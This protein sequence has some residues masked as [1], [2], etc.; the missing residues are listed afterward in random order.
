IIDDSVKQRKSDVLYGQYLRFEKR[1]GKDF[2]VADSPIE[3]LFRTMF[4]DTKYLSNDDILNKFNF[5]ELD[6]TKGGENLKSFSEIVA[7]R[8]LRYASKGALKE[9]SP[10]IKQNLA[11]SLHLAGET[12]KA[13]TDFF[14]ERKSHSQARPDIQKIS[15]QL[16]AM[17]RGINPRT[18]KTL[19]VDKLLEDYGI[20]NVK[21][22]HLEKKVR[23]N[24]PNVA[25]PDESKPKAIRKEILINAIKNNFA[26]GSL[27]GG[28]ND[29]GMKTL[30]QLDSRY[31]I[32]T[33]GQITSGPA[34]EGASKEEL[35]ESII[36]KLLT[37]ETSRIKLIITPEKRKT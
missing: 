4:T 24:L 17:A 10:S 31:S 20:N 14:I 3:K 1:D 11:Q 8:A 25:I 18:M 21:V 37:K 26:E 12:D 9:L 30:R 33:D 34:E 5:S 28:L 29:Y 35:I 19:D 27:R 23:K 2:I 7:S 22:D 13:L 16:M 32:K 6:I 15:D 36:N